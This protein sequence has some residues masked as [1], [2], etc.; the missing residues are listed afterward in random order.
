MYM[1]L[2]RGARRA[3]AD[4]AGL[5]PDER[6]LRHAAPMVAEPMKHST[7][8]PNTQLTDSTHAGVSFNGLF[9][10]VLTG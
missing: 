1:E 3:Y 5:K 10:Q 6:K 8:D 9:T 4:P 2:S 7:G